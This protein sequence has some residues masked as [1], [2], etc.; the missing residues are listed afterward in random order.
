MGQ[1]TDEL[2]TEIASTRQALSADLD[3]LQDR[4]SPTAIIDRRKPATRD[5]DHGLGQVM[6]TPTR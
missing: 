1:S 4:V 2:N 6:G 3:A 5:A